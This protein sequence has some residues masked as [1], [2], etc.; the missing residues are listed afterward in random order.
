VAL[1]GNREEKA[2]QEEAARAE[3]ERLQS[4][5]AVEFAAVLMP[6]FGPDGPKPGGT[7]INCRSPA[8]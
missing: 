3:A 8:G 7:S 6:A 2:A 4:L 5:T 1:F